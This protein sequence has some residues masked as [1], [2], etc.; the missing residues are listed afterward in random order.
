MDPSDVCFDTNLSPLSFILPFSQALVGKGAAVKLPFAGSQ[1]QPN[2][3][4]WTVSK[5]SA[6]CKSVIC[7]R[8]RLFSR[9]LLSLIRIRIPLA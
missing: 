7:S 5:K 9:V 3:A 4:A 1:S 8:F 2:D 6:R